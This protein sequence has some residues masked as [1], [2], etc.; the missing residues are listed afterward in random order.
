MSIKTL[1]APL[2]LVDGVWVPQAPAST[3]FFCREHM[4]QAVNWRGAGC[5]VCIRDAKRKTRKAVEPSKENDEEVEM[6]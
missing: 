1:G 4:D 3:R 2:V 5:F 6:Y